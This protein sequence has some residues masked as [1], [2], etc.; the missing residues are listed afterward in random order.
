[1]SEYLKPDHN[2]N[3]F[4]MV[5]ATLDAG[6]VVLKVRVSDMAE[7]VLVLTD[8]SLKLLLAIELPDGTRTS[9]G[10]V[11]APYEL[12]VARNVFPASGWVNLTGE[13]LAGTQDNKFR[14]NPLY[15]GG[16]ASKVPAVGQRVLSGQMDTGR[17]DW[18]TPPQRYAHPNVAPYVLKTIPSQNGVA[19]SEW[20]VEKPWGAGSQNY[21]DIARWRKVAGQVLVQRYKS[22]AGSSG[23]LLDPVI[24]GK[25]YQATYGGVPGITSTTSYATVRGHPSGGRGPQWIELDGYGRFWGYNRDGSVTGMAGYRMPMDNYE[26]PDE[27]LSTWR[28]VG[29]FPD[30]PLLHP[31]DFSY[32]FVDRKYVYVADTANNR[33][34][35]ISR[36]AAVVTGQPEDFS[37][38]V[39]RAWGAAFKR[40]TSIDATQDGKLYVV[41]GDGLWSVDR[42]SGAKTLLM[43]DTN[44]FWVRTTST[45]QPCVVDRMSKVSRIDP[46][47]RQVVVLANFNVHADWPVL[48]PDLGGHIGPRDSLYLING[49]HASYRIDQ[50]A[51]FQ[52]PFY[53]KGS[54]G[55]ANVGDLKYCTEAFHYAWNCEVHPEEPYVFARSFNMLLPAL[56]R[57][58]QPS[59][60][61]LSSYEPGPAWTGRYF[62]RRGTITGFPWGARPSLSAIYSDH[63]YS[64]VGVKLFDELQAMSLADRIAYIKGGMGGSVPRPELVGDHLRGVLYWIWRN[65]SQ[66]IAGVPMDIP[67]PNTDLGTPLISDVRVTKSGT[68]LTWTWRTDRPTLCYVRFGDRVPI[69]RW[70]ALENDFTTTHTAVAKYVDGAVHYQI[71]ALGQNGVISLSP[72][73]GSDGPQDTTPPRAPTRLRTA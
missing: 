11:T 6:S 68:Q 70:T 40:P 8:A 15:L 39:L 54:Y 63:G 51:T 17:V 45:G 50:D 48:S 5:H 13:V 56:F 53:F 36:H 35:R 28:T 12:T 43:A 64:G 55:E 33:L 1:M 58:K 44:L 10:V 65:S 47:T 66:F 60:G 72:L 7:N 4:L 23:F 27:T 41:D 24:Q 42:T 32:D 30:G 61:Y 26:I 34:V 69:Y 29:S 52:G 71:C 57:P 62:I 16:V 25:P 21:G 31:H 2:T 59:E 37:K 14:A 18:L 38:W 3:I 22:L 9:L 67:A 19:P 73:A 46:Q 20:V 49:A